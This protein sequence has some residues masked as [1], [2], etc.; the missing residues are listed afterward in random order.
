MRFS[1]L[2]FG[3]V[4]LVLLPVSAKAHFI[5]AD[6]AARAIKLVSE[7]SSYDRPLRDSFTTLAVVSRCSTTRLRASDVVLR[8][9][10]KR[11]DIESYRIDLS[12]FGDG[13]AKGRYLTSGSLSRE[14]K[15]IA[16]EDARPGLYY[17]FRLLTKTPKGWVVSGTGR[18][19]API[20]PA[21]TVPE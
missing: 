3:I 21:D 11:E 10:V 16:F 15:L 18:F 19:D 8:W 13:F 17:Y 20:C 4:A 12:E 6:D 9:E 5:E 1:L 2:A 7:P 14:A